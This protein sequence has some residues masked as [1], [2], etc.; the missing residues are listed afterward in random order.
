[1]DKPKLTPKDFFLYVGALLTL[2]VSAGSLI[3]LLFSTID[4][5]FRDELQY[6]YDPYS[7]GIR[8]AIA[9]LIVIFPLSLVLFSFIKKGIA[10]EP[11][12]L[13]LALRRWALGVTIFIT[14][15]MLAGDLI[16][17]LSGFLGGELTVRFA[18]K[19]LAVLAVSAAV[20]WYAVLEIRLTPERPV[21][22][23]KGFIIGSL[24]GVL[25]A[26][27]W[28]FFV[29]GSPF[30]VRKLRMDERRVSDLQSIQWQVVNYWQ[31]KEKF[32]KSLAEIEDPLSGYKT[33][34]DPVTKAP[35]EFILGDG[36]VFSLCANFILPNTEQSRTSVINPYPM[37]DDVLPEIWGQSAGRLCFERT[38]DPERSPPYAKSR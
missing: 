30:T 15:A 14:G 16:A 9:S 3:G 38:L 18:L 24:V 17:V 11:A 21:S 27:V 28:G 7:G 34:T 2:Y 26:V 10:R 12:K 37:S 25:A 29:M 8:F 33:P 35:Y 23:R 5:V 13:G 36:Y 22:L 4:R 20:F 31:Q 19:A 1:M 32:P 6:Y